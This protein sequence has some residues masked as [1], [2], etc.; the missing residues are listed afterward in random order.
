MNDRESRR[1]PLWFQMSALAALMAAGTA[2]AQQDAAP[3]PQAAGLTEVVVSA[4]KRDE[5]LQDVPMSISAFNAATLERT[6]TTSFVDYAERVPNL[7]F[8]SARSGP[9]G[10]RQLAIRGVYG[11]GTVGFYVDDTPVPESMDPAVTDLERIEVLRGPQGTL[12]GARSMGGTV[13]LITRQPDLDVPSFTGHVAASVSDPGDLNHLIE[14]SANLVLS[15]ERAAVRIAAYQRAESGM[16]SRAPGRDPVL[17]PSTPV[18]TQPR[19]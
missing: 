9:V 14:G 17:P 1:I 7:S 8:A 11:T 13:R 2:A 5:R 16:F 6:S 19:G 10:S 4:R 18:S 3:E 15:P 12:Y